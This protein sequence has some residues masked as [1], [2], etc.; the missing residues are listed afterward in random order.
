MRNIKITLSFD[1]TDFSGWQRQ[2]NAITI[3]GVTESALFRIT[4]APVTLHGAGRTDAGVHAL[5]MVA[6][7][8]T[9]SH[10][11]LPKLQNGLN[12]LLPSSIRIIKMEDVPANFHARFSALS[13]TYLYNIDTSPIQSPFSRLFSAHIPQNLSIHR[14]QQCLQVI[15]GTHDFESFEASGSRD[16]SII[17]GRGSIRTLHAASVSKTGTDT[18]QF[19]FAGDGFL[20]HMVRNIMGTI[21]NV[22]KGQTS[23]DIFKEILVAKNRSCAGATAP[24]HGLFLKKIYYK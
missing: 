14:M 4:N 11:A 6:S 18:Y 12:A 16:K 24:A 23:V 9:E 17:T 1:G 13:K 21:L 10:I 5:A 3:Q 20:R 15:S 8:T 7:F 22:G 19:E 2:K